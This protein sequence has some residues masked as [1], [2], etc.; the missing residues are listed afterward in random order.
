[1]AAAIF[2]N[3]LVACAQDNPFGVL[4]FLAWDHNWNGYMYKTPSDVERG[5]ELIKDLG[6]SIIRLDFAWP[7]IETKKGRYN[8]EKIDRIVC[9]CRKNGIQI[10]GVLGYS[11]PW[12]GKKWNEPVTNAE[13]LKEFITA[14]VKRYPQITHWE[15]WNEPDSKT[16]WQPQDE[17][18]T[19]TSLLK[20]VYPAMKSANPRAQ[21]LM[22]GLT[23]EGFY[24][25]KRI[26]AQ[27]G[28]EYFDIV[29]IHPFTDPLRKN[30]VKD[31]GYK[32]NHIRK[33]LKKYGLRKKIWITEIGC[34]GKKDTT[35]CWWWIGRCTSEK[36]Q[37]DF[38]K[39]AFAYLTAQEDV[40][41][42]FWAFFQDTRNH[43]RSGVDYFG[44]V[45]K[46]FSKKPA[47]YAYKNLIKS[48]RAVAK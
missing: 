23:S 13:L 5:V 20:I 39:E 47:F 1:M 22:G 35:S 43:F 32:L 42:V 14:V 2:L 48:R 46:D 24:A 28:G 33:E 37:A 15:F 30:S 8:F 18:K 34:P 38:L 17:M 31:I 19:Y 12:S 11:P 7:E 21:L 9:L 6:V 4:T 26:L 40:E 3:V 44:L 25:F 45:R 16:Y 29:N 41:K 27:G 36:E 10:L